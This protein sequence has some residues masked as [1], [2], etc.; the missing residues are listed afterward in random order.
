MTPV[1]A[2]LRRIIG[3]EGAIGVGRFMHEVLVAGAAAYYRDRDPLGTRGDFVTAPEISQ[4]FGE[5]IGLWAVAGWQ[6]MGQPSAFRLV[7]L[8]PGRGSLMA[9]ALRAASAVPAFA[10]GAEIH[11]VEI[12]D[13]LRDAQRKSLADRSPVWHQALD[14]VPPGPLILIANEF[15]DAVPVDQAIRTDDGWRERAITIDEGSDRLAWTEQLAPDDL[16]SAMAEISNPAPGTIYEVAPARNAQVTAIAGR[17][18]DSGGMALLIDY[19]HGGTLA[20]GDTVQAVRRHAFHDPLVDAGEADI[21]AHVAFGALRDA[22]EAARAKAWGP[23]PQG[24]FLQRLG[25]T[26]RAEALSS[27]ATAEQRAA[28]AAAH[29]RLIHPSEMGTLFLAL[30]VTAPTAPAPAGF[31]EIP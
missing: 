7:E 23:V 9:D 13:T 27:E 6:Q 25:L 11:L 8:G 15:L 21:S 3:S 24:L 20:A 16:V 29:H 30:A 22:A 1:E 26:A 12:N 4:M 10:D 2:R 19:G 28:I 18:A 17:C 14:S 31:E 5:L